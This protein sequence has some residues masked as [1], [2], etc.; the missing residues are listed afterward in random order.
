MRPLPPIRLPGSVVQRD[1][2]V[3]PVPEEVP[4]RLVAPDRLG[5][6]EGNGVAVPR[7][8]LH[9]ALVAPD[10]KTAAIWRGLARVVTPPLWKGGQVQL[11]VITKEEGN[12][13]DTTVLLAM[14]DL[15]LISSK[16]AGII[17]YPSETPEE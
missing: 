3:L 8:V 15:G 5:P 9:V 13:V 2:P 16:T 12:T 6:T 7:E 14:V 1:S 10:R 4:A 17:G 11:H